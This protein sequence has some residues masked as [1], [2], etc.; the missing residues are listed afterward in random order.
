MTVSSQCKICGRAIVVL[1]ED[2][3][4]CDGC[5]DEWITRKEKI[6]PVPTINLYQ[7]HE[8]YRPLPTGA[9]E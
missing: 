7:F 1:E 6:S 8:D 2:R 4:L 3:S 9:S 5:R